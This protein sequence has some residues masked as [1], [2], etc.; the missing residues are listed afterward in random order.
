MRNTFWFDQ[1]GE[2]KVGKCI[3]LVVVA[4]IAIVLAFGSFAVVDADEVA[5][6]KTLGTI[7]ESPRYGFN[8]KLPFVTDYVRFDKTTQRIEA[9]D[10]TYT[11]DIQPAK[12]DYVFTYSIVA[13][14]APALYRKANR[15]YAE[16]LVL[17]KLN[18]TMKDVIGRWTATELVSGR[19]KAAR[20]IEDH[21]RKELSSEFFSDISFEM[22]NIDYDDAFEKGIMA[23]VLAKE[24]ALEAQ[25]KTVQVEEESKQKVVKAKGE[26][27]AVAIE[28]KA[29][30]EN[31]QYL[32][33]KR[34]E[35][36]L[37][38]AKSAAHW[39]NPVFSASQSQ[40]LLGLPS[41][42]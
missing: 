13:D 21:L 40:L 7:D 15:N 32:E 12:V 1:D 31:P 23:K 33:A 11:K 34:V 35:A 29:L 16:K 17:P 4:I 14:N 22:A 3:T 39:G 10:N 26:A 42:K 38:M 37:E 24:K 41:G 6:A 19:D 20:E 18:S 25:N 8:F 30:R 2:F 27:E 9:Q 5:V 28:G 36:Q